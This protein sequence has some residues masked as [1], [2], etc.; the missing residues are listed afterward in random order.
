MPPNPPNLQVLVQ[1]LAAEQVRFVVIGGFAV[2]LHGGRTTTMDS[3]FAIATDAGNFRSI[4]SALAPLEPRPWNWHEGTTFVW[5]ERSIFGSNVSLITTA[6]DV[7]L[8]LEIPGID[9]FE[10][11]HS[12]AIERTL[13]A[14]AFK[15]ASVDDLIKM[16]R[17]A[18]R[19]QDLVHIAELERIRRV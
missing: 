14:T 4:A 8:L 2:V 12:R 1:A 10:G 9:S 5:D 15:I 18:N 17:A 11:L 16:K 7:D 19:P 13:G 6:G 3:D